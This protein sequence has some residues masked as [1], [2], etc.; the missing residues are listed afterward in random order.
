[1][2][3]LSGHALAIFAKVCLILELVEDFSK[4]A[5]EEEV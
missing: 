1:V 2:K 4:E 3:I 5:Q